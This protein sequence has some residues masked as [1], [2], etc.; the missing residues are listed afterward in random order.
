M[1]SVVGVSLVR[2]S[3]S[4]VAR[5][6]LL[7]SAGVVGVKVASLTN[8]VG[9]FSSAFILS[10]IDLDSHRDVRG[11]VFRSVRKVKFVLD[12]FLEASV[13][14]LHEGFVIPFCL[15]CEL[16]EFGRMC[17]TRL[18]LFQGQQFSGCL[19]FFV[20]YSE[21]VLE[22]LLE[23]VPIREDVLG[24]LILKVFVIFV[25]EVVPEDWFEPVL[26]VSLDQ[27]CGVN[28]LLLTSVESILVHLEMSFHSGEEWYDICCF[29]GEGF[30]LGGF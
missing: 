13:V 27:G 19:S 11:E 6:V 23:V 4:L 9:L 1:C 21:I 16:S 22:G 28:D 3:L 25:F 20:D 17:C 26:G 10:F 14:D 24:L 30:W 15:G 29:T 5:V 7:L 8:S 18:V 2:A 12:F